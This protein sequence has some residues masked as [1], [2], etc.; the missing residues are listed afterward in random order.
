MIVDIGANIGMTAALASRLTDAAAIYCI[1]PSPKAFACLEAMIRT[2]GFDNCHAI[3][4]AVGAERGSAYLESSDTLALSALSPTG[5]GVPVDVR[6]LDDIAAEIGIERLDLLKI[7]VEGSELAALKGGLATTR[8]HNPLVYL[9]LNCLT[10]SVSGM[11]SPRSLTDFILAEWG[12]FYA[13]RNRTVF[14]AD[15]EGLARE[16]IY[17]NMTVRNPTKTSPLAARC[18]TISSISCH[19]RPRR[20]LRRRSTA[21][22]CGASASRAGS[23]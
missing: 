11:I 3:R 23:C 8:T 17:T 1:E 14:K 6:T 15:S 2:N 18:P 10:L 5:A 12:A 16:I 9:E 13:L 21:G 4:T 22:R 7:D 19:H 20:R